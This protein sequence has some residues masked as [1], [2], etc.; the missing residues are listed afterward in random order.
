MIHCPSCKSEIES[1]SWYCDQCGIEIK[2]CVSCGRAGENELC[3]VCG[4]NM[5]PARLYTTTLGKTVQPADSSFTRISAVDRNIKIKRPVK[6][7]LVNYPLGIR[8][9]A[10]DEAVIGRKVGPYS[11]LLKNHP[12][13]SGKH[14]VVKHG[15][16]EKEWII[17]DQNSS[18]GTYLNGERI[19]ALTPT[20][21]KEGD[22]IQLANI[23]LIVELE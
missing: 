4:D 16:N 18:N 2:C 5:I 13:V 3:A 17:I 6:L 12:Y 22:K 14:A 9:E 1:G 23:E 7:Y 21:I 19:F 20:P 15:T 8:F 10:V 11:T